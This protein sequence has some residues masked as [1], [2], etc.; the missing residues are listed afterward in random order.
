MIVR[1]AKPQAG[2]SVSAMGDIAFL[3]MIFFILSSVTEK[4]VNLKIDLP[5]SRVSM[6]ENNKFFNVWVDE[7]GGIYYD[8]APGNAKGLVTHAMYKLRSDPDVRVLL[9]SSNGTNFEHI[10]AVFDALK[11]AG[12]HYV[13]LVSEKK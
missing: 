7:K 11:E 9:R 6:Q 13:V 5:Q 8:G 10:N 1:R 3:L 2:I 12:V 4:E